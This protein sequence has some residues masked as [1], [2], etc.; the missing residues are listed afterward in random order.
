MLTRGRPNHKH[1]LGTAEDVRQRFL[2]ADVDYCVRTP[3]PGVGDATVF[4]ELLSELG[5]LYPGSLEVVFEDDDT[6]YVVYRVDRKR[7]RE[8]PQGHTGDSSAPSTSA[9]E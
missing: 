6:Q 3:A 8:A 5:R 1:P 2:R 4:Q 9:V 7:R